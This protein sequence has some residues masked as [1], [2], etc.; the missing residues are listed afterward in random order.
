MPVY[1]LDENIKL[2]SI[3]GKESNQEEM[4][5]TSTRRNI[6][7]LANVL[8]RNKNPQTAGSTTQ[9]KNYLTQTKDK[10]ELSKEAKLIYEV[11]KIKDYIKSLPE[12][13]REEKLKEIR[14]SIIDKEIIS[15]D[16]LQK[17]AEKLLNS[18]FFSDSK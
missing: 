15:S 13:E 6:A 9:Q 8:S 1:R 2:H 12:K 16:I 7:N 14:S 17:T 4:D 18:I 3:A 11:L 10:I 5:T